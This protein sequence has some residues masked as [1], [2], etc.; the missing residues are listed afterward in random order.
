FRRTTRREEIPAMPLHFRHPKTP[1]RKLRMLEWFN[2]NRRL[3]LWLLASAAAI[4]GAGLGASITL[5]SAP[6][7]SGA[8]SL[9]PGV[10]EADFILCRT[11]SKPGFGV[12][13]LRLAATQTE[14]PATEMQA[15]SPTP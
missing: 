1:H 15:V 3:R 12:D 13:L 11:P 2:S 7:T 4:D 14:V 5:G 6:L 9:P 8:P 10:T